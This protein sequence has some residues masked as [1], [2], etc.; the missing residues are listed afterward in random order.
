[1][2]VRGAVGSLL[3]RTFGMALATGLQIALARVMGKVQYGLYV[4]AV[5]WLGILVLPAMLGLPVAC[6]RYVASYRALKDWSLLRGILRRCPWLVLLAALAV[7]VVTMGVLT[8]IRPWLSPDMFRTFAVTVPVLVVTAL[9]TFYQEVLKGLGRVVVGQVPFQVIRPAGVG[10]AVVGM[11]WG[12]AHRATALEAMGLLLLSTGAALALAGVLASRSTPL[13]VRSCRPAYRTGQWVKTGLPLILVAG[14]HFLNTQCGVL[15]VGMFHG[16]T[17][18][19]I[20]SVA[21]RVAMLVGF[22]LIAANQV[23]APMISGFHARDRRGELQRTLRLAGRGVLAFCV[24]CAAGIVLFGRSV[25]GLWGEPYVVGFVPLLILMAGHF[26]NAL[27]MGG[28]F[29]MTMTGHERLASVLIG[30]SALMNIVLSFTLVPWWGMIGGAVAA[31]VSMVVWNV[32]LFVF[33]RRRLGVNPTAFSRG[34][35]DAGDLDRSQAPG[36]R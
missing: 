5:T 4:Y 27:N 24:V 19:G 21:A 16:T 8:I 28:G 22:G 33:A 20:Y 31:T 1:M 6:L 29:L 14:A 2:L 11:Y 13:P 35:R 7:S 23:L 30:G 9:L 34:R 36:V 25:L 3:L 12:V 18:A 15:V 17:T 32:C 26:I 10:L